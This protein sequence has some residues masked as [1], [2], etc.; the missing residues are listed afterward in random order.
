MVV[1]FSDENSIFED[2]ITDILD[3]YKADCRSR[4]RVFCSGASFKLVTAHKPLK[5]DAPYCTAVML[6]SSDVFAKQEFPERTVGIYEENNRFALEL[7]YKRNV[8]VISCGMNCKNTVTMSAVE[9][10]K[11]LV[12]LQ[13]S[14]TDVNGKQIEQGE[15]MLENNA[16]YHPFS[17]M[18]AKTVLLL[19]GIV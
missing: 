4:N 5:I 8:P 6:A 2:E 19:N 18:A 11:P 3:N 10:N 13:R 15:F 16:D 9:G 1:L 17:V 12:S 14:I 7:F